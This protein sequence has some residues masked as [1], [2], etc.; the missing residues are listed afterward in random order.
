MKQKE[1]IQI[2]AEIADTLDKVSLYREASS[3]T[4]I[5]NRIVISQDAPGDSTRDQKDTDGDTKTT[6]PAPQEDPKPTSDQEK[7]YQIAIQKLK[8]EMFS[9][10]RTPKEIHDFVYADKTDPSGFYVNFVSNGALTEKQYQAFKIQITSILSRYSDTNST[11]KLNASRSSRIV[12]NKIQKLLNLYMQQKNLTIRDLLSPDVISK[13]KSS[14]EKV[15]SNNLLFQ[16]KKSEMLQQ[17]ERTMSSYRE[18]SFKYNIK[19]AQR[20]TEGYK[21]EDINVIEQNN[22]NFLDLHNLGRLY[23]NETFTALQAQSIVN[24]IYKRDKNLVD[25]QL[26]FQSR[27]NDNNTL[28]IIVNIQDKIK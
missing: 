15:I 16:E 17:L 21:A 5:M 28:D 1:T 7:Q 22:G 3:I 4:N 25:N 19:I 18:A 23:P 13:A 26:T 6:S 27:H 11:E 20:Q 9:G 24:R 10:K 8:N 12:D 2:L 14:I